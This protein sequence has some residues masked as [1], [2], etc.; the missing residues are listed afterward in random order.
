MPP[1]IF[2]DLV[3]VVAVL[4]A[5]I[6]TTATT[7]NACI[8]RVFEPLVAVVAVLSTSQRNFKKV[9][10]QYMQIQGLWEYEEQ[11]VITATNCY[12]SPGNACISRL[13]CGSS[14][15]KLCYR[16]CYFCYKNQYEGREMTMKSKAPT[17]HQLKKQLGPEYRICPIDLERCLYRDFGNGFNV[18]ISGA[19]SRRKGQKVSLYLWYG[20]KAPDCLIVK[21]VHDVER[22][23][24]AIASEVDCLKD[25]SNGLIL[26]GYNNRDAIFYMLHPEL[27][28]RNS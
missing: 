8:S 19:N 13:F 26:H 24:E 3:A 6:I 7:K 17:I 25:Y 9:C 11:S 18:E 2:C 22:T 16:Y 14:L 28:R 1:Q 4:V 10:R 15:S 20:E 23:A 21:R 27:T 5:V 12:Q